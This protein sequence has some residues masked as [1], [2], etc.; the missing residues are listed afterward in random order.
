MW[1]A[2]ARCSAR[3]VTGGCLRGVTRKCTR[4]W[5]L[6]PGRLRGGWRIRT[7]LAGP[8]DSLGA[9]GRAELVQQVADVLFHR[10]EGDRE[11]FGDARVRRARG[12]Q[13]Q[14]FPLAGGQLLNQVRHCGSGV[15]RV[16]RERA[17]PLARQHIV[18]WSW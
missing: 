2:S 16:R 15:W 14:D 11:L 6:P 1:F 9:V 3:D 13:P 5:N 12:Q 18:V 17:G 10:V 8:G 4:W 7:E